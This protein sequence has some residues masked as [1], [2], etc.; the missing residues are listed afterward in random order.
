MR[1]DVVFFDSGGTLYG[2]ESESDPSPGEVRRDRYDRVTAALST[3][4]SNVAVDQVRV[5]LSRL[6]TSCAEKLGDAY[7]YDRL[8]TNYADSLE[9]G[10]EVAACL[11][12]A[13]AGPRYA[14]W[15]FEGT[16][17][18]IDRLHRSGVRLGIIANTAWPGF[19]MDRAFSGVGLFA[20]F[21]ARVYSGDI[22]IS[23]PD[24]RIF[25][26]AMNLMRCEDERILYVG[27]DL[28][29]DIAGASNVGWTTAYRLPPSGEAA[30]TADFEFEE[31][32]ALIDYVLEE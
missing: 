28:E 16:V 12:D 18:T 23:K 1:F 8:M 20:Y 19:C 6:E 15:L 22:G 14:S 31:T 9:L 10:S 5:D 7:T 30:G 24:A 17:Q 4:G 3:F 2:A 21:T 29:K 26:H 13:Y 25:R 27:N 11:A 32:R